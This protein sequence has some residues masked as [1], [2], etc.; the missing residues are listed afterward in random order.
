MQKN[1][2]KVTLFSLIRK[3]CGFFFTVDAL[4]SSFNIY[5]FLWLFFLV[6]DY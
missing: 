1:R 2:C 4:F 6:I 3:D 5:T